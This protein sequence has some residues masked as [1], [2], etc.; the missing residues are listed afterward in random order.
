MFYTYLWLR[1][2]GTPYYVGK[3]SGNRAFEVHYRWN[4][5]KMVKYLSPPDK[6]NV[7]VQ[8]YKDE[9][10]AIEAEVFL[11]QFYGRLDLDT[12]MLIN[13]TEGGEGTSGRLHS[14]ETKE[15]IRAKAI[16]RKQST[17]SNTKRSIALKGRKRPP[18]SKEWSDK[19]SKAAIERMSILYGENRNRWRGNKRIL[20]Q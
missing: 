5:G 3:G 8:Q 17:S 11:I 10:E 19:I 6:N 20:C 13:L 16:E 7:I 9:S 4:K 2:D 18:R 15:K 12:G 14:E 1:E